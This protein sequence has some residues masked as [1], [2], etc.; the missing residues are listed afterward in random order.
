MGN[1]KV[2]RN[3]TQARFDRLLSALICE[4][5]AIEYWEDFADRRIKVMHVRV[6]D[7]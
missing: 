4:G 7:R 1:E 6:A 3:E 2:P 5:H